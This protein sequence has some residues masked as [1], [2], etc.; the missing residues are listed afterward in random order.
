MVDDG[1]LRRFRKN[2]WLINTS[3]GQVVNTTDL[4]KNLAS[5]QSDRG[6]H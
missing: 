2:I 4:V 3:R 6:S 1:F 5:G